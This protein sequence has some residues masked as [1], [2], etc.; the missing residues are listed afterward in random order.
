MTTVEAPETIEGWYVQHDLFGFQWP[1]WRTL[2]PADRK[3]G[4]SAV[5]LC[6][7]LNVDFARSI[8]YKIL[9][10]LVVVLVSP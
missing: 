7:R 6:R 8:W 5:E 4:G 9:K 2:A 1:V 3:R 10:L